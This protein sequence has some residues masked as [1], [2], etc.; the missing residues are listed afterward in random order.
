[1]AAC[2][3][4]GTL[5][6]VPDCALLRAVLRRQM[7][8]NVKRKWRTRTMFVALMRRQR[9]QYDCLTSLGGRG[10]TPQS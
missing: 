8:R 9:V 7:A 2:C 1:M 5:L 6:V 3:L 10:S 4:R